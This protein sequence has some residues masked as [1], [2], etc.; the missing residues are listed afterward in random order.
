MYTYYLS[1]FT[2][3]ISAESVAGAITCTECYLQ[4]HE[5]KICVPNVGGLME[6]LKKVGWFLGL[7][8]IISDLLRTD[9]M[10]S[11]QIVIVDGF[12]TCVVFNLRPDR[13]QYAS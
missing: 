2:E 10:R 7:I 4:N 1:A 11:I 12:I 13:T 5:E 9:V 6:R 3:N 8:Q